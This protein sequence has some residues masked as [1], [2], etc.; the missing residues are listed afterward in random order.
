MK[1]VLR[2]ISS[3]FVAWF[4][5]ITLVQLNCLRQGPEAYAKWQGWMRNPVLITLNA[6]SLF[7]VVMHAVTWFNLA[8]RAMALRVGGK[9]VPALL[10]AVANYLGWAVVS[11]VVAWII[12]G[13]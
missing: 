11:A 6:V 10:I 7:F 2:E 3:I 9:R 5:V 1:F 13:G 12:L 8:P 4:V